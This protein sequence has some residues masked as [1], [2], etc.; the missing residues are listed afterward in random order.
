MESFASSACRSAETA[1]GLKGQFRTIKIH[2][3]AELDGELPRDHPVLQWMAIWAAGVGGRETGGLS[4]VLN[5]VLRPMRIAVAPLRYSACY[6]RLN[7]DAPILHCSNW[8]D[9]LGPRPSR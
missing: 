5:N 7:R 6:P 8:A 9:L 4:F 1:A 3:E 2:V